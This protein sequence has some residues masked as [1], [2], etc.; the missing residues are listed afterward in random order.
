[1]PQRVSLDAHRS[2]RPGLADTVVNPEV[3]KQ[4]SHSEWQDVSDDL[5]RTGCPAVDPNFYLGHGF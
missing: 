3:N 2:A 5:L 1:M 4:I